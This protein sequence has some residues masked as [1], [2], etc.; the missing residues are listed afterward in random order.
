VF[1]KAP[2]KLVQKYTTLPPVY[3][4]APVIQRPVI[5]RPVIQRPVIQR[6]VIEAPVTLANPRQPKPDPMHRSAEGRQI[7]YREFS[8][9]CKA[10]AKR[11]DKFS[12]F[13]H[14][15]QLFFPRQQQRRYERLLISSISGRNRE[16]TINPMA[17]P[18]PTIRI[19]SI[20]LTRLSVN[21]A[22]SSSNVSATL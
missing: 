18:R 8:P 11:N 10:I 17:R 1:Q 6:P 22:T 5:Q 14:P 7:Q 2:H 9:V 4:Q 3:I 20:R 13:L 15:C 12:R 21:T 19:G 16:I